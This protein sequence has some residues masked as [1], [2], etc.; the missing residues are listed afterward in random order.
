MT[1]LISGG[2]QICHHV[3]LVP[4][5]MGQVLNDNCGRTL[6]SQEDRVQCVALHLACVMAQWK[7]VQLMFKCTGLI[8]PGL[9]SSFATFTGCVT[10]GK[11]F[12]LSGPQFAH[13]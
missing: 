7:V 13:L 12:H 4:T 1:A 10:V 2:S 5:F 11:L 6:E 3:W 8:L 9:R